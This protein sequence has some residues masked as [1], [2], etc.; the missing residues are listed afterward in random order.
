MGTA[1]HGRKTKVFVDQTDLTTY[2]NQADTNGECPMLEKTTFGDTDKTFAAGTPDGKVSLRGLYIQ[3]AAEAAPAD[4]N[5]IDDI[6]QAALGNETAALIVSIMQA[7]SSAY[8][9]AATLFE[10][11]LQKYSVTA[12]HDA[13]ISC[14]AEMQAD[15]GLRYGVVIAPH[16]ARTAT[17]TGTAVDLSALSALGFVAHLHCTAA[18]TGD[19]LNVVIEDSADG[20]TGWATIGTFTQVTAASVR[21][22]ESTSGTRRYVRARWTIAGNGSESFTFVVALA[23]NTF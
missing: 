10:T 21:R 18:G 7:G 19:T 6:L 2:L 5:A 20:S 16:S 14:M 9:D 4:R 1:K 22:V 17:G 12:P 8:G 15:G 11:K 3:K 13:L 23:R